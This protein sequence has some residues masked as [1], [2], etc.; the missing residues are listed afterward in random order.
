MGFIA[1]LLSFTRST[2]NDTPVSDVKVDRG[3]GSN[4]TAEHF[5]SAG[6]DS[7]PLPKDSVVVVQID[8]TGNGVV[9]GYLD[10]KNSQKAEKGEK[11]LYS[12]D[13]NGD[14]KAEVWLKKNGE[15]VLNGGTDYAVKYEELKTAY[16]ELKDD[17]N[18]HIANWNTFAAAYVPGG[19]TVV[20]L[21]PTADISNESTADMSG[22]K[23]ELVRV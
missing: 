13:E 5:S 7:H 21:P 22:S 8:G 18:S 15:V 12:R 2:S 16:D 10:P 14:E 3:G 17:L 20:G 9:V 19:P 11:R 23:V 4:I 1:F 6:D